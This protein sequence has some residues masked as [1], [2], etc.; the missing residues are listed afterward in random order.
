[1]SSC[2]LALDKNPGVC[3]IRIGDTARHII[4]KA[5]LNITRQ[6]AQKPAGSQL[7][8]GQISGIEAA[9][10][11]VRSFF[12][13]EETEALLLV[14]ASNAFNSLNQ[15][16]ALHNIQRLGT[17]LATGLINTYKAPSKLNVDGDVLLFQERTT[18][19]DPQ[20]MPM[21]TLAAIPLIRKPK[22]SMNDVNQVWYADNPSGGGIINSLH[23]WW[24]L[25]NT[26]GP[27][28]GYFTNTSK[29]CLVTKEGYLSNAV[30][31]LADMDVKVT[32]EARP[33]LG[34]A[35][36]TEEYTKVFVAGKAL[37]WAGEL[38]QLTTI[39]VAYAAF[40]HGIPQQVDLLH[41][42]HARHWS[43][44]FGP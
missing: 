36:G 13:R 22:N 10:H 20:A 43:L 32:T 11:A 40:T 12:Q 24:D 7:C 30:V 38:Q 42:H 16:T 34:V 31:F 35:L 1:M 29:T 25:T 19:G 21:Y 2:L 27:K 17:S 15:Q 39:D 41:S 18:Q 26:E 6:D 5:I 28:F 9:V 8:A 4:A 37:Q 23:E 33:F 3:P 44:S 14:D